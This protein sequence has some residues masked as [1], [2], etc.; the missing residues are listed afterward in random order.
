MQHR[1]GPDH[2]QQRLGDDPDLRAAED[3]EAE[4]P[5]P[6][7]LEDGARSQVIGGERH[8]RAQVTLKFLNCQGSSRSR[9]SGN[10]PLRSCS[11]VQVPYLPTTGPRY[12]MQISRLRSKSISSASTTPRSGFSSAQTMPDSTGAQTWIEVA[13]LYGVTSRASWMS[14]WLP[15]Q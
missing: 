11:G 10:S 9:S 5:A 13:L 15:Y 6:D 7:R 4:V 8:R 14:S 2:V 3:H 1:I 12:G